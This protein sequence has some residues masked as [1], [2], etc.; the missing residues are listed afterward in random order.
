M[1]LGIVHEPVRLVGKGDAAESH[2]KGVSHAVQ[3]G[4]RLSRHKFLGQIACR[5]ALRHV[6]IVQKLHTLAHALQ[7]PCGVA[8]ARGVGHRLRVPQRRDVPAQALDQGGQQRSRLGQHDRRIR[9]ACSLC[10]KQENGHVD[11]MARICR[12]I[13]APIHE[14]LREHIHDGK[15]DLA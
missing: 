12:H 1:G 9:P 6:Q 10:K 5:D 13:A 8:S 11:T 4:L 3:H 7:G 2:D 14:M 15:P